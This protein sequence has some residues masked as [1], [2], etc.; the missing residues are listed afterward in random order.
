MIFDSDGTDKAPILDIKN[1]SKQSGR[2]TG[3]PGSG[4]HASIIHPASLSHSFDRKQ[5]EDPLRGCPKEKLAT[6]ED[7]IEKAPPAFFDHAMKDSHDLELKGIAGRAADHM[8]SG[9]TGSHARLIGNALEE[10]CA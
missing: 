8:P 7:P 10:S 3:R 1:S 9:V 6:P 5:M 2:P 4:K